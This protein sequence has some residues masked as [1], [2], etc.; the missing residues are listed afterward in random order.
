[1]LAGGASLVPAFPA[2]HTA[3][4]GVPGTAAPVQ[5][6]FL[7]AAGSKTGKL[8]PTGQSLDL[9]D[10]IPVTCI[11]MAMPMLIVEASELGKRGDESPAELDADKAFMQRLE[12][13]RLK[14]GLA[15]GL[16]GVLGAVASCERPFN[17]AIT[18]PR[19]S[20]SKSASTRFTTHRVTRKARVASGASMILFPV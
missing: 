13:L 12:S 2:L 4:D 17:A 9:I 19:P 11:D 5:L 20:L 7:D 1:M 3:I 10:G 6:T 15:M 8:F 18:L 14:A 16:H